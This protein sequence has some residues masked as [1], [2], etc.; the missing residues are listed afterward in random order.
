MNIH[1]SDAGSSV[2]HHKY[3]LLEY[4]GGK[5][6]DHVKRCRSECI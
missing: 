3:M 5:V 2:Y 4:E 1:R 6:K